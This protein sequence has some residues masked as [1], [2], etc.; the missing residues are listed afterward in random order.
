MSRSVRTALL[1]VVVVLLGLLAAPPS[2]AAPVPGDQPLPGY[3][4][5]NPPLE[6]LVVDGAPTTVRQGVEQHAAYT[7]E[8]PAEWN[9]ELLL[10]AHGFRGSTPVLTVDPPQYGL[11]E[12]VL[13]QGY[14]WAAS[15]YSRNDY[16]VRS[17]VESTRALA[18][19]APA[20]LGRAPS[21]T[22]LAGVSMGGHVI[23]RSL[24]QYPGAYAGA[25]PLCGV[26]GDQQLFDYFLDYNLVAQDFADVD[27]YPVPEDYLA[28]AVPRIQ[29]DLG[30][31]GL[32]PGGPD[33]LTPDGR[34]L[35]A[36]TI[37]RT[38]GP[39]PG[40]EASFAV[41]KDFLFGLAAPDDGGRLAANPGRLA[42]NVLTRYRPAAPEPVNRT[43]ER[44]VPADLG[45]RFDPRLTEVPL[46]LGRP[47]AP[48]VSLH[49]LGDLFVPFSMEQL[50]ARDVARAGQSDLLVQRAVRAAQHC[51]FSPAEVGRAWDDLTAW[52]AGGARPAGD[53]V[54]DRRAVADPAFGC[55]F[56][57]PTGTD[58]AADSTRALF[59]PCPGG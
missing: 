31:A 18:E 26:L 12:R 47:G 51:E 7:L 4:I 46:V 37:E 15:S 24:E 16:D 29:A 34:Q 43:V 56:S 49:D 40:D 21:R 1:A 13:E 8:V 33:T 36:I 9:G 35:R 55:R 57:D 11:R 53:A 45:V 30:L 20:L 52:V 44:V 14:A 58:P 54:T 23:A 6:P 10:W 41:W 42:Q 39:R 27:A 25:L 59:P 19:L 50:Y 2:V 5:D 32:T 28:D 3:T 48:V 22:H 17:G 38:G